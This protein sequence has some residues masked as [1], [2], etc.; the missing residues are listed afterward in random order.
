MSKVFITFVLLAMSFGL[1]AKTLLVLGDSLSA[2]HNLRQQDGWV[3]L[4]SEQLKASHPTITVVNASA[5]GETT[6]GGLARLPK[7]L[8]TYSPDWVVLEL[9]AN[10]GLRGYP[11]DQAKQKPCSD[12]RSNPENRR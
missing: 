12:D 9:G 8:D 7:L 1:Q 2:A 6:Q 4:L 5:S 11:L 3:S 10:D